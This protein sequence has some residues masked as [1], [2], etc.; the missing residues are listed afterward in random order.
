RLAL[1]AHRVEPD[2][3]PDLPA[4]LGLER[5]GRARVRGRVRVSRA[6]RRRAAVG[7]PLRPGRYGP[8][9]MAVRNRRAAGLRRAAASRAGFVALAAALYTGAAL[10]ATW[11]A[12]LHIGSHFISGHT[13]EGPGPTPSDHLQTGWNLWLFGHQLEHG[14]APWHDPYSFRPELSPRVDFP[15][16]VFGLPYWPLFALFGAVTAWN[17]FTLATFVVARAAT[18]AWLRPPELPRRA[19]LGA[20]LLH[21]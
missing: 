5:R 20:G 17:L 21:Q 14:H 18:C 3:R 1:D 19:A 11:P 8:R 10:L 16:L 12:V 13:S 7:V 2:A 4:A 15:G 6:A 9:R